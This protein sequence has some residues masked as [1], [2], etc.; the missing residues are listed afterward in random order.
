M[1]NNEIRQL[2]MDHLT[3][4]ARN[5]KPRAAALAKTIEYHTVHYWHWDENGEPVECKPGQHVLA[6]SQAQLDAMEKEAKE[7][8]K[9]FANL[10]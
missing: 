5:D 6:V 7:R 8:E 4:L 10:K 2:K 3:A 1:T 9:I